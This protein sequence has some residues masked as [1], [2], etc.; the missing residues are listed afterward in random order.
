MANA[1]PSL[2]LPSPSSKRLNG[3]PRNSPLWRNL[4]ICDSVDSTKAVDAP[5]N[6]TIHI[7]NTAPGP[8]NAMAVAT[9]TMFPV[10]TLPDRAI[11]KAS[12][13]D[14][15]S[16]PR[17]LLNR[18]RTISPR[19]RTCTIRVQMEKNSPAPS[20]STTSAGFQTILLILETISFIFFPNTRTE[21]L[22]RRSQPSPTQTEPSPTQTEPSPTR[23]EPSPLRYLYGSL[24]PGFHV[25]PPARMG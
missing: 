4:Y 23:T 14:M 25:Q 12:N 18:E 8:S 2:C 17:L 6:A 11:Q 1:T 15:P 24:L 9:P 21:G 20:S 19:R 16:A 5:R 3:P 7:Q 10:P 13:D 22:A